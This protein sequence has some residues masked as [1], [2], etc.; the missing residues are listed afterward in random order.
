MNEAG[1]HHILLIE[2]D[3]IDRH[4]VRTL[5][6]SRAPGRVLISEAHALGRGL[7]LLR[8]QTYDLV[9]LDHTMPQLTSMQEL[10]LVLNE[11]RTKAVILHTGYI[12]A[13]TEDEALRLGVREVVAKGALDQLWA[14]VERALASKAPPPPD[15]AAPRD[16]GRAVLLAEDLAPVRRVMAVSLQLAGIEVHEA[17]NGEEAL[18]LLHRHGNSIDLLITDL[19]MPRVT[20]STLAQ[21]ARR[22]RPELPVLF[23]TGATDEDLLRI[24]GRIPD[25]SDIL[26]KPFTPDDLQT[27]V[28]ALLR[29]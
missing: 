17:T 21:A 7:E 15:V 16:H 9:L 10:R 11:R 1:V 18:E 12:S 8:H 6:T 24:L 13:E 25:E 28:G 5:L 27:R 3:E 23:V 22:V 26:R 14:S 2:D 20:G 4:L 29:V 19:V